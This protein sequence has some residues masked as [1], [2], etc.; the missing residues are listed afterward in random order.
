VRRHKAWLYSVQADQLDGI[1]SAITL[2]I[3]DTPATY[4]DWQRLLASFFRYLRGN[5]KILRFHWV[6]EWQRR[7]T[8]HVHMAVYGTEDVSQWVMLRW[9]LLATDYGTDPKAQFATDIYGPLGWLRYLSKHASRGVQHYQRQGKPAGWDKTGRLWGKSHGW[10]TLLPV[11]GD[12]TT[13]Q[14][15]QLRRMVRGYLIAEARSRQDWHA[16]AYLRRM[17]KATSQDRSTVRGMSE[18]VPDSVSLRM[19]EHAGW[20]G[21]LAESQTQESPHF[22]HPSAVMRNHLRT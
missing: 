4:E 15:H 5:P 22:G 11:H 1:G 2:T 3:R 8:P 9:V 10:P 7:G 16:V 6:V 14:L 12:F 18:F 20:H 13:H 21:Q 17:L 19:I